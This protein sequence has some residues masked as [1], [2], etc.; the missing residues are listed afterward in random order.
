MQAQELRQKVLGKIEWS[1]WILADTP[2]K[3]TA[4]V[5][6]GAVR[7]GDLLIALPADG[8]CQLS[9]VTDSA[10]GVWTSMARGDVRGWYCEAGE[11]HTRTGLTI[12]A[13][14]STE[15]GALGVVCCSPDK[16][17]T[18]TAEMTCI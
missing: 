4:F 17:D 13:M 11:A 8:G 16:Y 15:P 1:G 6:P 10:G 7:P 14:W 9:S 5:P 12:T 3:I 18:S 2:D